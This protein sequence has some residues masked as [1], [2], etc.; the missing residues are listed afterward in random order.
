MGLEIVSKLAL[1]LIYKFFFFA[2]PGKADL[3]LLF[4][5]GI[6]GGSHRNLN[7]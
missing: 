1:E 5:A 2:V 6:L 7:L 3:M 4:G